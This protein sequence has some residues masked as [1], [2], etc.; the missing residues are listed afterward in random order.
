MQKRWVGAHG[1][2]AKELLGLFVVLAFQ[3]KLDVGVLVLDLMAQN[4]EVLAALSV[5]VQRGKAGVH[6]VALGLEAPALP[7]AADKAQH[8][9][10]DH[11]LGHLAAE[12]REH[13]LQG[14]HRVGCH[15]NVAAQVEDGAGHQTGRADHNDRHHGGKRDVRALQ[16]ALPLQQL[17][18][19]EDRQ[20]VGERHGRRGVDAAMDLGVHDLGCGERV[21]P[22]AHEQAGAGKARRGAEVPEEKRAGAGRK[23]RPRD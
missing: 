3:Q 19:G 21:H 13:A 20:H 11:E 23:H 8:G 12:A 7:K 17:D 5:G 16:R 6:E 9:V 10:V 18:C 22:G 2:L 1:H 15:A 14:A 4:A